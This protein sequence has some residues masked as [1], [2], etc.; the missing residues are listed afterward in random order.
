VNTVRRVE[1]RQLQYF[2]AVADELHFGR[3][4][5]RLH[6]VPAA[7][8]QQIQ[9][10][11][12]ELGTA[13]F[14]RSSRRVALTTAGQQLLPEA[15]SVLDAMRRLRDRM[16]EFADTQVQTMR[17]GT[18]SGLGARL[19]QLLAALRVALPDVD[20]ELVRTPADRRLAQVADGGLD[21][22]LIRGTATAPGV[23]LHH[24]WDDPILAAVPA[25]L[26][27][28]HTPLTLH[29]L[30][31]L[32]L[33][34]PAR[35]TNPPLVDLVLAACRA[36]GF[37]PTLAEALNDQDMLAAIGSGP[38]SWTVYYE[39]QARIMAASSRDVVFLPIDEPP[40][41]MATTL[42]TPIVCDQSHDAL[43]A[44]CLSVA[45]TDT[46]S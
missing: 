26:F 13:L 37:E 1:L 16:I 19:G 27:D 18:S 21:A 40:L 41:V 43:L 12:R 6:I 28:R 24:V 23:S 34:L 2:V 9:R 7:V 4:A 35:D 10:L 11:E 39:P 20:V 46:A 15:R 14:D 36:S 22:A 17:I 33:R 5:E 44:A 31:E 29:A 8:T 3:A 30:R 38:S 42:A 25:G 45:Q 32:P